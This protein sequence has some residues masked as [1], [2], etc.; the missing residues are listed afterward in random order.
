M[1]LVTGATGFTG[2]QVVRQLAE[3]GERPLCLTRASSDTRVVDE[4]GLARRQG[5]LDDLE[6]L[7]RA[8]EGVQVLVNIASLGFG[9]ASNIMEACRHARVRR[10]IFVSTTAI[11]TRLNAATKARRLD[12]EQRIQSSALDWTILRPTMIYGNERDRNMC[13]LVCYVARWPVMFVA[14]AGKY[15]QQPIHVEDLARA[16]V[17]SIDRPATHRKAYNVSGRQ[18]LT[19]NEVI[20]T[21]AAAVGRRVR[22]I[23]VPLRPVVSALSV[24]ERL[25]PKPLLKAEQVLRL[26]EDKS[27]PHEEAVRDFGF[28]SRTFDEGI[29][30]QVARMRQKG[31]I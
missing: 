16:I 6:S 28:T 21:T 13:R 8:F 29:R 7:V 15:L 23:H 19:F 17:S 4:L 2:E 11:F 1:M 24:Y 26:E 3:R 12:A 5:D 25:T 20:D 31:L 18:P 10:A 9:H 27:F 14:G 30:Q 22:R